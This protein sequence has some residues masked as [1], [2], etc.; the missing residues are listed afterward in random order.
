MSFELTLDLILAALRHAMTTV[1]VFVISAGYAD[2]DTWIG[3]SGAVITLVGFGW[4]A[5]RKIQRDQRTGSPK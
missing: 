3:V 4:S 2:A 5:L 1:G